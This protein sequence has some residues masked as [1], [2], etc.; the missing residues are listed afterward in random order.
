MNKQTIS[1]E[2][3]LNQSVAN[4]IFHM[5][6]FPNIDLFATRLNHRLPIYESPI[7][8]KKALT[9]DALSV[10]WNHIH[11]YAFPLFHLIQVG[12]GMG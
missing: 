9:I 3:S 5:T 10:D 6:K 1:T 7:P 4:A 8:D 2:W 12:E 11:A